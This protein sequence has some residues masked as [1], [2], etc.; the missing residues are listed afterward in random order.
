MEH[1]ITLLVAVIK[2]VV[3]VVFSGVVQWS[4]QRIYVYHIPFVLL[5][6]L[7]AAL[8]FLSLFSL[9]IFLLSVHL[10]HVVITEQY[11]E[12][13]SILCCNPPWHG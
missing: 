1:L 11:L 13:S 12:N 2:C 8:L 7:A 3:V 4:L 9:Y 6:C 5:T 10:Y